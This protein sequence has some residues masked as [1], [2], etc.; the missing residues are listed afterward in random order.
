MKHITLLTVILLLVNI[1]SF[2]AVISV[3]AVPVNQSNRSS[4]KAIASDKGKIELV[5]ATPEGVT[6]QLAIAKSDFKIETRE[7]NG[8]Q[9]QTLSFP[10]CRF[11]TEPRTPRLP[12]QTTLIGVPPDVTFTVRIVEAS[13]FSSYKLQ[14]TLADRNIYFGQRNFDR[15]MSKQESKGGQVYT[16]NRFF[17]DNL[18]K[19]RT[20]GWIRE[21]RV[22]P[23]Q[24]NPVQYNPVSGEVR[25]YHR[26]VVE[27]QFNRFGSAPSAIQGFQ[28]SESS[29]YEEIFGNL[30]INPQ[31]AKQWRSPIRHVPLRDDSSRDGTL[32]ADSSAF[33][34][35]SAPPI[36]LPRYKVIINESG[37][38]RITASDL[39]AAGVDITT[40]RPATL[41][42][43]NKGKQIPIFVRNTDNGR[44]ADDGTG[45]DAAGEIIF[46]GQR[47]SGEKTYIDPHSDENVY[48]LS[49]NEGTGLRMETKVVSTE[50]PQI[51]LDTLGFPIYTSALYGPKNF[52]TRVH[53][54]KDNQFRRFKDFGLAEESQYNEIGGGIQ[55]RFFILETLPELPDD[56]WFWAQISAPEIKSFPFTLAGVAETGQ[57][58]TIRVS[59]HGRSAGS[60]FTELWLN[61]DDVFGNSEWSGEKEYLFEN[62]QISQSYLKD[63]RNMINA[64]IPEFRE[65][66]LI[67]LNWFEIDY[68][69]TFEA[70][71]GV[72]PFSITFL[73]DD[74]T[75]NVNP[76]FKVE[77]KNFSNPNI[78]IY[79][80]DGTRYVGLSPKEDED[81][82]GIY[83][84][85]FQSSRVGGAPQIPADSPLDTAIQYIALT[86]DKYLKPKKII[87]DTLSDLQNPNN[88]ADYIIITY[89]EF[90]RDV[91]PLANFRNQQG[92]RT[93]VVDVQNIYDEFNH[94]IPNPYTLREFLKYAYENWQSPAPTYV[95]LIG[96]TTPKEKISF[97]PTIQVQIPGYGSSASDH[98]FVT[99]RGHDSFPDM[100]IGRAPAANSIDA[101]IFVERVINYESIA[102]VG[103]WHKR[104]LMLAGSDERFHIQTDELIE[105]RQLT[106]KYE[107]KSIYAPPTAEDEL[108]LGEGSTPVG[109]QVIEGFNDGATLVN[110]IG[111]GGGGVWSSSRMMDLEDPEK[112]LT[113]I[114]QLPF[115]ISM[116]C[117]TG[118]F[119]SPTGCL[120]EAL[121]RSE[122]GGAIAV[123][124]GT[125]I[126]L[127]DGDH[128]LNKEIFEVIFN[129]NTQ[130]IGAIIAEAKTQFLVN[131]PGFPDL[132]EVFTLF[133]DPATRL[134]LPHTQMQVSVDVDETSDK[135]NFKRETRLSISGTLPNPNFSGDA[136]ITV[137]PN[138]PDREMKKKRSQRRPPDTAIR[139]SL[140]TAPRQETVAVVDGTFNAQI[141]VP[142]NSAFDA[143]KL[144]VYA[145]NAEEDAIGHLDYTPLERYIKNI[146]LVPYPVPPDQPVHIY[147]DAVN[148][149]LI[150]EITLYWS[151]FVI[152]DRRSEADAIPLVQHEGT[153]YRTE[154]PIP[155]HPIGDLIDY[156]LLVKPKDGRILHTKVVTYEIGESDLTV[157]EHTINWS[158]DAP[159]LLSAQIKNRGTLFA[160]NVP[161]RFFQMPATDSSEM[162]EVTLEM[163]QNATPIGEKIISEVPPEGLS[164]ASVPW[165]PDPGKYL[166]T[167]FVD[168]PSTEQPEGILNEERE[169]NNSASREFVN[170]RVF[171]TAE[172]TDKL[173]QSSDGNLRITIPPENSQIFSVM[174]FETEKL[175]ITNQPD[176]IHTPTATEQAAPL[177][178]RL[179]F[180][181][182][183]ELAGTATF[184]KNE[185]P[186]AHIYMRDGKT[187][188]WIRVGKQTDNGEAI[189][190]E[191]K[192][193]GT[194]AL[195]S[196]T[197]SRPPLLELTV[198]NQGFIN[199]DYISDMPTIS[200]RIEDANGIDPRPENIIL[201][202]N[203]N[204]VPRD[205]YTISASP[206]SS[207]VL[208]ITYSPVDALQAGEYRI[209]LQAQDAN[210]NVADTERT[211]RVAGGFQIKY[212]ANF[213]NPFRPGQ[214]SGKG[215]N[216]AYYL[217]ESAD[218]VTLKIYT[219]TGKLITTVDTLDAATSYNEY[220][221]DGLDA[222]GEPL[223][224]GVY[225]Y[226]FTATNGD[227]RAQKV[228]K[229]AV[230]K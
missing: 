114:S 222:D 47:H 123:I 59:L 156:Y 146:R 166:V 101:R 150:D 104:I 206:I 25:L 223:A 127:L 96:D 227:E 43:S 133:G 118:E 129:D 61:N 77:L 98:Q 175:T 32:T 38:Y 148:E 95:L 51:P 157:L 215:T 193:P 94:G 224:N 109:R 40:I 136:E 230:L 23:I 54:E 211:A 87:K 178:Y 112:N 92:M 74:E 142:F 99:F 140:D 30:L 76:N 201:T 20:A 149:G 37:M 19:I 190:A 130:H 183:T 81:R 209:R 122:S 72:L 35:P 229:I 120:A 132:A 46:Y 8:K 12:M 66:D 167:V 221:F 111:H 165:Q 151:L 164:L 170:N 218:K 220:H 52:L 125:S 36:T 70:R 182:P 60:H 21:N 143:L 16:T 226:K 192:L 86:S 119:D 91:Q 93:K 58:A 105:E 207:N 191:V 1:V 29:V 137:L 117:F 50:I 135:E 168:M 210:G 5:R 57:K 65:L 15:A 64:R 176:I 213:P 90:V 84:V 180:S 139:R 88:G 124:G 205:E 56:S 121:L 134:R 110:Y 174:T 212:I 145:W 75:G 172:N 42:L 126:G 78:E 97:V 158:A 2:S 196:H 189:S 160:K 144:K 188:N 131:S 107:T 9:F 82:M 18:A 26:L 202:K 3:E 106:E 44:T 34:L 108:A 71:E 13:D 100:L 83:N 113:N 41:T 216:F 103:P 128:L 67:M 79:G 187:G 39:V 73:P 197:D 102:E 14:H 11:T 155:A 53:F 89:T 204:R 169:N 4:T 138:P 161:V 185:S 80:V 203:G 195:L 69:R 63:G 45:F 177:A 141:Q 214:G 181:Q 162:Q 152:E 194:F 10:G 179:D 62:Q 163:L 17:P 198:E 116:T 199:G 171:L 49:W 6:I 7:H 200:A 225:I 48:W 24:L 85:A 186:D 154:Q 22:L 55:Q 159:F 153:T 173:I 115:V 68:W 184:L 208:L 31:T 147:A 27:V 228:G 28:R 217:T 33:S 219:L